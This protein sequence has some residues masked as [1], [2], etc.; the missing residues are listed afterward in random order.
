MPFVVRANEITDTA[1]ILRELQQG[2]NAAKRFVMESS[3]ILDPTWNLAVKSR[4]SMD[5]ALGLTSVHI[6]YCPRFPRQ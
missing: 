6:W 2:H 5:L 3:G 1:H 4:G